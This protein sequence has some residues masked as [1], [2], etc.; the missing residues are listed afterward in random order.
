MAGP[1]LL[2]KG[3]ARDDIVREDKMKRKKPKK[4]EELP[5][6]HCLKDIIPIQREFNSL[7]SK[8]METLLRRF[9]GSNKYFAIKKTR[10]R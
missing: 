5:E 1:L 6:I 4:Q 8:R 7:E 3:K 9:T 10:G 2:D